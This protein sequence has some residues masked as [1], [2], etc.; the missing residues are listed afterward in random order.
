VRLKTFDCSVSAKDISDTLKHAST[1]ERPQHSK[2][3]KHGSHS[4]PKVNMELDIASAPL[5]FS[6]NPYGLSAIFCQGKWATV[7]KLNLSGCALHDYGVELLME[8][9]HGILTCIQAL[10]LS[11]NQI[12]DKGAKSIAKFLLETKTLECL[13]LSN[14]E[15]CDKGV[16][17]IMNAV[18]RN[19]TLV[20]IHLCKTKMSDLGADYLVDCLK[21]SETKDKLKLLDVSSNYF[22][23]DEG[24]QLIRASKTIVVVLPWV[25]KC[26]SWRKHIG[27][28][29]VWFLQNAS[30]SRLLYACFLCG[31]VLLPF[32]FLKVKGEYWHP[33]KLIE[34]AGPGAKDKIYYC[35]ATSEIDDIQDFG[36]WV[37]AGLLYGGFVLKYIYDTVSSWITTNID[38]HA[39]L[40]HFKFVPKEK[41]LLV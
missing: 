9:Q 16:L 7:C 17:S 31:F 3:N 1:L 2:V 6:G 28:A 10:N 30:I 34:Q 40:S 33:K 39:N 18:A 37:A 19:Q 26:S 14:N 22:S 36:L 38:E 5:A 8:S 12:T 20:E 15:L 32:A 11:S 24:S 13:C 4:A 21:I 29:C 23:F 27:Y 41:V 25:Y 35:Y